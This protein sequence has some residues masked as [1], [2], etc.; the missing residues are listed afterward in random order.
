M[1]LT[2]K[3]PVALFSSI[4][5]SALYAIGGFHLAT[6]LNASIAGGM[7]VIAGLIFGLVWVFSPNRGLLAT[8]FKQRGAL[9]AP[10]M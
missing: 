3:L 5:F 2:D 8:H 6:W 1:M 9:V 10:E 7:A 4:G